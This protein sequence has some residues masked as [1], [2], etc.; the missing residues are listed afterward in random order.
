MKISRNIFFLILLNFLITSCKNGTANENWNSDEIISIGKTKDTTYLWCSFAPYE[1]EYSYRTGKWLFMTKDSIKIANGEYKAA[2]KEIW[3]K[4]GCPY[5]YMENEIDYNK[6][7]FWNLNG[8]K[9]EPTEKI[10]KLI[11]YK[12]KE[13][14]AE[15]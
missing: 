10:K 11:H 14:K 4:G 2:L 13:V 15:K 12:V 7:E 3:D 8:E 9:I 5:E 1:D 6:W